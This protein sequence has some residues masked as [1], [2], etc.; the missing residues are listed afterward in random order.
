[1]S[2]LFHCGSPFS[3]FFLLQIVCFY[4][5]RIYSHLLIYIPWSGWPHTIWLYN[6]HEL[7]CSTFSVLFGWNVRLF[8]AII[9]VFVIVFSSARNKIA[10]L[11]WVLLCAKRRTPSSAAHEFCVNCELGCAWSATQ[12][13]MFDW[14]KIATES[15][16]LRASVIRNIHVFFFTSG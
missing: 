11:F 14:T 5:S 10:S 2:R 9:I 4:F 12:F 15:N 1:M 3:F 6:F 8:N 16:T 7:R 13:Q